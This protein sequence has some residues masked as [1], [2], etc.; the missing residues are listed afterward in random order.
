MSDE[1]D[2]FDWWRRRRYFRPFWDLELEIEKMFEELEKWMKEIMDPR[3][4]EEIS[5]EIEKK[6]GK[7][8]VYGPFVYGYT[9]TI[10]P[11]GRPIIREFGNVRK[12][13]GRPIVSEEREPVTD[14]IETDEEIVVV[15]ELPGVEKNK[16]DVKIE[17]D[18]KLII[19]ASDTNRRYRKEVDLPA[20]VDPSSSK[21]SY[22][23]GILEITL[24][25]KKK[26][27]TEGTRINI[28]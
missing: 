11:D 1:Y 17:G 26:P 25:K 6:G 20:P 22:K 9:I 3:R 27:E 23:N 14:V 5:K 13:R 19:K 7:T 12:E 18:N 8:Y 28:E 10:G 2:W 15:A 21:A 16:I 24:K 4:M